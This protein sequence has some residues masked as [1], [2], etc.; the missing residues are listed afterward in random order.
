MN[1]DI[2]KAFRVQVLTC[3]V[4]LKNKL[5][6]W[7]FL[8]K[9]KGDGFLVVFWSCWNFI[10][11]FIDYGIDGISVFIDNSSVIASIIP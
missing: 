5:C 11:V 7:L 4:I 9:E 3:M 8:K 1:Q 10:T 2:Y 6:Y